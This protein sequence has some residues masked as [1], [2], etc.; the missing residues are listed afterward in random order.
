M[1][2]RIAHFLSINWY[3]TIR[4][5]FKAFSLSDAVK[6]SVIVYRG[7]K[8][9]AFTGSINFNVPIGFGLIGFG[10]P[11]EI[12]TRTKNAGEASIHG[13]LIC[14]GN[15][16]FGVDTKLYIHKNATLTLGNINSFASESQVICFNEITIG[17]FMQCGS[18]CMFVD[19]NFHDLKNINTNSLYPKN[20]SIKIGNYVY[21]G[22]QSI[23]RSKAVIGNNTLVGSLSLCNKDYTD[24]GENVT[25]AGIPAAF[26]KSGDCRDWE[27]EKNDLIN[28]LK[29]KL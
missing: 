5:N 10:Q 7:F 1:K 14:N 11:Y 24:F 22:T 2:A 23:I 17:N 13:N 21:I 29:I 27:S 4:I 19:T 25:L 3:Q 8:I 9:K 15:V 16:Q 12:F 18:S 6:L 26:I 20:G 28:Y